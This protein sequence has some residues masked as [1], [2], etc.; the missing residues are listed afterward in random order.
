MAGTMIAW[1]QNLDRQSSTEIESVWVT[2]PI[3]AVTVTVQKQVVPTLHVGLTLI[4][5]VTVPQVARAGF[6]GVRVNV[7]PVD[8]DIDVVSDAVPE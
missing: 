1:G 6:A 4:D 5:A 2:W 8:G 7:R 3:I